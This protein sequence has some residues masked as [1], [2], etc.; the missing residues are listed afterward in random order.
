[1]GVQVTTRSAG[2]RDSDRDRSGIAT[3]GGADVDDRRRGSDHLLPS[4]A[5]RFTHALVAADGAEA[6]DVI[7]EALGRGLSA[8]EVQSA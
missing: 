3:G 8:A 1:M 5:Q 6:E 2:R 7:D 4:F